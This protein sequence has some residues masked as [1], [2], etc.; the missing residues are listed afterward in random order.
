[1]SAFLAKKGA[2]PVAQSMKIEYLEDSR[3][4][5]LNN[6]Q[7]MANRYVVTGFDPMLNAYFLSLVENNQEVTNPLLFPFHGEDDSQSAM[8]QQKKLSRY[9]TYWEE[10]GKSVD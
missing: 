5:Q 4:T 10:E 7:C 2:I 1:M 3:M 9:R 8:A 6:G